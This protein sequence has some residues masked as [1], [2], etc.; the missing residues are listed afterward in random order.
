MSAIPRMILAAGDD[1]RREGIRTILAEAD[2]RLALQMATDICQLHTLLEHSGPDAVLLV[3]D[4]YVFQEA[5]IETFPRHYREHRFI[6]VAS[7]SAPKL[8]QKLMRQAVH[9]LLTPECSRR[10]LLQATEA[11]LRG[12]KFY[13]HS[14]VERMMARSEIPEESR[15]GDALSLREQEVLMAL[16]QGHSNNEIAGQ[17]S[18]SLHTIRTHRRNLMR[19]IGARSITEVVRYAYHQGWVI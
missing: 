10:E 3:H 8:L 11:V 14:V 1:I 15:D 17:L 4:E 7:L 9:G 19:K 12:D 13:C 2:L 6:L 5:Q 18:L 16:A